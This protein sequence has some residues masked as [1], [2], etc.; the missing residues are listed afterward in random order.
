MVVR[1]GETFM[2]GRIRDVFARDRELVDAFLIPP[3]I[4]RLGNMIG[5]TTRTVDEFLACAAGKRGERARI[6][7]WDKD[8]PVQRPDPRAEIFHT[9]SPECEAWQS[10]V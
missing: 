7:Y 10:V 4:V 3:Q 6:S 9:N 2:D 1:N 8:A 5:A